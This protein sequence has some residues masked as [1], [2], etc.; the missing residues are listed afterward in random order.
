LWGYD[1][2]NVPLSNNELMAIGNVF[3]QDFQFHWQNGT[4]PYDDIN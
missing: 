4:L 1:A 3:L 2:N